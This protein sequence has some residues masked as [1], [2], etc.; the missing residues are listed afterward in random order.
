MK[1]NTTNHDLVGSIEADVSYRLTS[2]QNPKL[3][4]AFVHYGIDPNLFKVVGIHF[5]NWYK[6]EKKTKLN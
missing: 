3:A 5:F 4:D 1:A 2:K 6:K